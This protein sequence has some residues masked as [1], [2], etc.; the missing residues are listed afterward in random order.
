[1]FRFVD[2]LPMLLDHESINRHLH[3]YF[4]EVKEHL[5]WAARLALNITDGNHVLGRALAINARTNARRMAERFI[6]GSNIEQVTQAVLKIRD[7]GFAF[8]L[9][10]LGETVL[11]DRSADAYQQ[12]YLELLENLPS[13]LYC[14]PES[15]QVDAN[16]LGPIPRVNISLK[17]SALDAHFNPADPQGTT[18]RVLDR[19]RP[20]LRAA[21]EHHVFVNIDMEQFYYKDLTY[22]IFRDVLMEKEFREF[23]D[24]GIVCQAYLKS[25]EADLKDLL[26]WVKKRKTPV[27]VRLVKGAYWDYET[28][29][30]G[31]RN[32]PVPVFEQKWESDAN[33]ERLSQVL[34]ANYQSLHPAFGS[35][36]LRS[37]AS[38]LATA[39]QLEVPKSAFELQMLYGMGADQA[40]VY[41]ELGYRVRIYIP[42]GE[43]IPGMAYLVRRLLENTSNDSFLRHSYQENLCIE[44]L[45]KQPAAENGTSQPTNKKQ[46]EEVP[47]K[48][49]ES[50][51]MNTASVD[52]EVIAFV[53]E[54]LT[55]FSREENRQAMQ[56]A[57]KIVREQFGH[58][59]PVMISGKSYET[60]QQ[61]TSR[62]PFDQELVVGRTSAATSDLTIEAIDAARRT[63]P[64]WSAIDADHRAEYLDL[65]AR[66]LQQRRFELAAWMV[67]ESAKPWK[68]A[69]G[70]VAEAIDFCKYYAEQMRQMDGSIPTNLPGEENDYSYRPRG[71]AVVIAPWNFP[72]AILTGMTV[73]SIVSGNTV[74]MKPSEKSPIIAAKLMEIFRT[75]G[76]PDGV[77]N[78]LPGIG[79]DI[80]PDLVGSPNVD[81]IAFTGSRE[82]GLEINQRAAETGSAHQ[83]VKRV[84]AELGGKNAI[85]IDD[86]ADLDDAVQGVI[87]SAFGFSG[88]KC[89]ACSRLVIVEKIYDE[90]LDRLQAAVE[91]L[92]IGPAD[93]PGTQLSCVIDSQS[94]DRILEYIEMGS[95]ESEPRFAIEIDDDLQKQRTY[96]GPHLFV[97]VLP[98]SR[99]AQEEIFG[100]VVVAMKAKDF[101]EAIRIANGTDY[102]LTGGVYSRSPVNLKKARREFQVGNLYLNR[103]CTGALVN[104]QPFGG[105][106]MSGMGSKSGGCDY[107]HQF[108]IPV[109]VTENTM[110]RGF[111]PE[112]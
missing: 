109:N 91:S 53:N 27:T 108:L 18:E 31:L 84:I 12:G 72:L 71:V 73:A 62:C 105:F 49:N 55:D 68:E 101:S 50:E 82:V 102:A 110:R 20:I 26:K 24:V 63:L 70:D 8:T 44:E 14:L 39:E 41:S 94:R 74:V 19:L 25:A 80:G 17:L 16:Y 77:V 79:E 9:D 4:E 65:V 99:L 6:A 45:L 59:Y 87:E 36:N 89:S 64:A 76:L 2:V 85:I 60:R 88:Q 78:Y 15:Q 52:Q 42:F 61:L 54:P 111:A 81:V 10:Q 46:P 104:R 95:E 51:S 97:D 21:I 34:L 3:E 112:E 69:D 47:Q 66:E 107:L 22:Q 103:P 38:V 83:G 1:M 37:I 43:Q 48:S 5:P 29:V 98:D 93:H 35:H 13:R 32:W 67:Y 56:E 106:R 11:S 40:Q 28:V 86:D 57:L 30:A 7:S 33:F 96:V 23:S 75:I 90:F 100:P 58:E 92:Q